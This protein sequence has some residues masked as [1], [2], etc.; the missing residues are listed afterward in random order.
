M[1][2]KIKVTID[3]SKW[4]TGG[5]YPSATGTGLLTRLLNDE[6]SMCC[7][8]FCCKA[9]GCSDKDI[10]YMTTPADIYRRNPDYSS[11]G[12][13]VSFLLFDTFC[14]EKDGYSWVKD[15]SLVYSAVQIN[16][17]TLPR[18]SKEQRLLE[19]FKDSSFE[20]EF[21]GEYTDFHY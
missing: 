15:S 8:G 10:R 6:G 13:T 3:R 21:T 4:R 17:G 16:D 20:I 2:E 9:A 18:E 12:S 7:L 19:L 14:S 1:N 5:N 11:L